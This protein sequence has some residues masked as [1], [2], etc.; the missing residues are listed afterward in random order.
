MNRNSIGQFKSKARG[1]VGFVK[2]ITWSIYDHSKKTVTTLF[3]LS[4]L[5]GIYSIPSLIPENKQIYNT[6]SAEVATPTVS[7]MGNNFDQFN[8][9]LNSFKENL[10]KEEMSKPDALFECRK[11]VEEKVNKKINILTATTF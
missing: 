11:A 7:V 6:A 8:S 5:F 9:K 1:V 3:V 10:V 4:V 2:W